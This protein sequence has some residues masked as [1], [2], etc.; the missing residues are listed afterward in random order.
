MSILLQALKEIDSM[1]TYSKSHLAQRLD[2]SRE[3]VDH[4]LSQ[5]ER[6]GYIKEENINITKCS[7]CPKFNNGCMATLSAKPINTLCITEKGE[8][9]IHSS[10]N[11]IK[12][13]MI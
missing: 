13:L 6:M 7:S 9:L 12:H 1:C 10:D 4:L 11:V 5:L 3:V 8:K 2:T